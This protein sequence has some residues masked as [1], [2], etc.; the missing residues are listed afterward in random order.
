MV[1]RARACG[2]DRS[3]SVSAR[4][5]GWPEDIGMGLG[6][7]IASLCLLAWGIGGA[8]VAAWRV[9]YEAAPGLTLGVAAGVV[10]GVPLWLFWLWVFDWAERVAR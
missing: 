9:A 6:G 8:A 10:L 7:L 2:S 5:W 4:G 3:D 1:G